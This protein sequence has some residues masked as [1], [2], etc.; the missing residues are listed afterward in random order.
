MSKNKSKVKKETSNTN[1]DT[2]LK[3]GSYLLKMSHAPKVDES[4]GV[5]ASLP[6]VFF[7]AFVILIVRA[8][9]YSMN[10][11][12]FPW[13]SQNEF[14]DFFSYGKMVAILICASLT[15]LILLYKVVTQTLA[16]KK[17]FIYIPMLVYFIFVLISHVMSSHRDIALLG[18]WDR[19]EGTLVLLAYMIM[20]FFAINIINSE[21]DI[22]RVMYAIAASSFVLSLIGISQA[23]GF[24][25]FQTRVGKMLILPVS[26]WYWIDD[27]IFT[28]GVGEIYQTVY[29]LNYVSFYLTLLIPIFALLLVRSILKGN[30]EKLWIKIMWGLLFAL[31]LFNLVGSASIGGALGLGF[32]GLAAI[33]IFRNKLFGVWR[34]P[35]V[36]LLAIGV[37]IIGGLG[38]QQWIPKIVDTINST[39]APQTVSVANED[40]GIR[41][42]SHIDYIE[43]HTTG[44]YIQIKV[45]GEELKIAMDPEQGFIPEVTDGTGSVI[46][47]IETGNELNQFALLDE[48]FETVKIAGAMDQFNSMFLALTIDEGHWTFLVTETNMRYVN[49]NGR[50]VTLEHA[51]STGF[52]NNPMFGS[53]RGYIWSRTIPMIRDTVFV[54][55]GADTFAIFFPQNDRIAR[56]NA[57]FPLDI[58]VDKP[59]NLYLQ[60]AVN[61]GLISMIAFL[62]M[63]GLYFVQSI[64]LYWRRE[65]EEFADFVGVGIFLGII[66]FA[67]AALVNDSSVSV[68]PIF[69]G[70]FGMGIAINMMISRF[71]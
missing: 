24:D 49:H 5:I 53:G 58:L 34:K 16:I 27:I 44:T 4:V 63:L 46:E 61:T 23:I 26:E 57:G 38:H 25:F 35:V 31:A 70:L 7:T 50:F 64:K 20:L 52:A 65:F 56:H 1:K 32:S 17:T 10:L 19:F 51:E 42:I 59:H 11:Q 3:D 21:R 47:I 66:G 71:D 15:L 62:V 39:V 33:I 18:F 68:M 45:N 30:E 9:N 29:N 28:F 69:Y 14:I 67:F 8:F 54:G 12:Q 36:L 6:Y 2:T 55:H 22:K 41:T 43:Q 40:A 48:R 13:G 60:M 37:V